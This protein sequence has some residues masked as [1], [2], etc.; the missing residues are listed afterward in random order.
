[1]SSRANYDFGGKTVFVTGAASGIG[2][3]VA[4][5]FADCGATVVAT[6]INESGLEEHRQDFGRN[7]LL[8][9]MDAGSETSIRAVVDELRS[10]AM[11]V[12]VLV[13][14]A[15]VARL[16]AIDSLSEEE[17]DVQWRVLLRGPMLCVKNLAPLMEAQYNASVINIASIAATIQAS[18]HAV[19]CACKAGITKFTQDAVKE[20]PALRFNTIQP[21]FIDTP[22]LQAYAIGDELEAMKSDFAR[23]TPVG[24]MG[25][26]EDI[27]DASLF[28]ASESASFVNGATLKLDGGVTVANSLEFL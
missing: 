25:R 18:R 4:R 16:E 3:G 19:Y 6:D 22:I 13:N 21:G 12:D 26:T 17:M 7:A 27:A 20:I 9:A 10:A 2:L 28:L 11:P 15:G 14:N 23:R 1:M 8:Y 5:A 24:R